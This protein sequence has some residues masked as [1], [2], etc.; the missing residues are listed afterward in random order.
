MEIWPSFLQDKLESSTFSMSPGPNGLR[1]TVDVGEA[2]TRVLYTKSI[3]L[4]SSSLRVSFSEFE[5]FMDF[6]KL[7]LGYGTKTFAF[8]HPFSQ[9]PCEWRFVSVPQIQTLGSGG[10]YFQVTFE[11]ELINYNV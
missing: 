10:V 8:N 3:D 11:W 7:T 1:S 2:K 9:V 5:D 6:Y 4:Y